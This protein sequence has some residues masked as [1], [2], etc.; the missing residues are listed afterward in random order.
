MSKAV[1]SLTTREMWLLQEWS[2]AG[3]LLAMIPIPP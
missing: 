2:A 3:V 1:L